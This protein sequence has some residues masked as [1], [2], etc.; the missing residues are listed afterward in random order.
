MMPFVWCILG[1]I[2]QQSREVILKDVK[3]T[4]PYSSTLRNIF[5][6]LFMLNCSAVV[7][8][9]YLIEKSR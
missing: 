7:V 3:Y 9:G 1:K 2:L 6:I 4:T 8:V 5:H